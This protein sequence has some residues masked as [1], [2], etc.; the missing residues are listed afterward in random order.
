MDEAGFAA[1]RALMPA[2]RAAV[3]LRT[4]LESVRVTGMMQSL[5]ALGSAALLLDGRGRVIQASRA[6]EAL[7][8]RGNALTVRAGRLVAAD[9]DS[10][11]VFARRL[12][13]ALARARQCQPV[14]VDPVP[15]PARDG[16]A[17]LMVELQ[18]LPVEREM[19]GTGAV[20][21]AL[22][23]PWCDD[24]ALMATLRSHLGLT[25][26]ETEIALRL[27]SGEAPLAIARARGVAIATVRSQVQAVYAKLGV[28]H[29]TG[30]VA[31][32]LAMRGDRES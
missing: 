16:V 28:H 4:A 29:Q 10:G 20:L 1:F 2:A 25:G 30:L 23:K 18:P 17:G 15:L 27:M 14:T 32:L 3:R 13:T 6:A 9:D 12:A 22:L 8:A 11:A 31:R 21:L 7:L 26:A 5:D 19:F 24:A